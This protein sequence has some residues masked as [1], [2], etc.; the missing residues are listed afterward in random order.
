MKAI[1][2]KDAI[3][4]KNILYATDFSPVAER[5]LPIAMEIAQSFGAKLIAVHAKTPENYAL[6]AA[7][8]WP[9]MNAE[10]EKSARE[11]KDHLHA[12]LPAAKTEVLICEGG[13]WA[14]IQGVAQE[15]YADLIVLGTQGRTGLEKFVLGSVAEEI[16]RKAECPVITVGPNVRVNA[17]HQGKIER[18]LFATDFGN[19][20]PVA[21]SYVARL[22][23]THGAYLTLLHVVENTEPGELVHP[24]EL[25]EAALVHLRRLIP[26][27][28][29]LLHEPRLMVR[30]GDAAEKILEVAQSDSA[31]LIVLGVRNSKSVL[32]ATHLGAA[33][34]HQ[35]IAKSGCPVLTVRA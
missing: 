18:I 26:E 15:K 8:V 7:D 25:E 27:T 33:V 29:E 32:R 14:V 19:A 1:A 16:L 10:I 11:L 34:A 13:I 28:V 2:A 24:R 9:A 22:G 30:H 5:A 35:V 31:D 4:I 3:Q 17:G 6:A 12:Q 23:E 20:S 21:A